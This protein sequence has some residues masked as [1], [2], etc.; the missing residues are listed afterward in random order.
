MEEASGCGSDSSA[1][2]SVG[3]WEYVP[4]SIGSSYGSVLS[5]STGDQDFHDGGPPSALSQSSG[6]PSINGALFAGHREGSI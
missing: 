2:K 5:I 6:N 1:G 3:P 4:L